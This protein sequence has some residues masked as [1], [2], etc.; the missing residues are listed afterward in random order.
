MSFKGGSTDL[1]PYQHITQQLE[2][3]F[4]EHLIVSRELVQ[5]VE[6]ELLN[7]EQELF[8]DSELSPLLHL[9]I[10]GY[11]TYRSGILLILQGYSQDALVLCRT[12][13]ETLISSEYMLKDITK[14]SRAFMQFY[15]HA[16]DGYINKLKAI[17]PDIPILTQTYIE[18]HAS[19]EWGNSKIKYRS[20]QIGREIE[21]DLLYTALSKVAHPVPMGF[22][23]YMQEFNKK[24]E[25]YFILNAGPGIIG[26]ADAIHYI[27]YFMIQLLLAVSPKLFPNIES[28]FISL[29][30]KRKSELLI[31]QIIVR[32]IRILN[33]EFP[34]ITIPMM[35]YHNQSNILVFDPI[36]ENELV[37]DCSSVLSN[38]PNFITV[39]SLLGQALG[40]YKEIC[41]HYTRYPDNPPVNLNAYI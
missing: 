15:F 5:K 17:D 19:K 9:F 34:N 26:S 21:Y 25:I 18:D 33:I 23:Y 8:F 4:K 16:I 28:F 24:E 39:E 37:I 20:E 40:I 12:L 6:I 7:A 38:E 41:S 29:E 27:T 36:E 1:N 2:I 3:E 30:K 32:T 22:N 31:E 14:R 13:Q 11:K 10:K 35:K